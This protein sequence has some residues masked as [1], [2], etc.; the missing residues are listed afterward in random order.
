MQAKIALATASG[1]VYYQLISE[2]KRS[3][4]PFIVINPGETLPLSIEVAI[5]TEAEKSKVNCPKILIYNGEKNPS[6]AREYL[7]TIIEYQHTRTE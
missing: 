3:R 7:K 5:T 1:R 4:V 6:M 2:L